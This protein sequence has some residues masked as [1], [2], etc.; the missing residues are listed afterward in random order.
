MCQH[1]KVVWID[2]TAVWR[3]RMSI[4]CRMISRL[5]VSE[6]FVAIWTIRE[7]NGILMAGVSQ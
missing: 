6:R 1:S 5:V 4:F 3:G 2:K 7:F